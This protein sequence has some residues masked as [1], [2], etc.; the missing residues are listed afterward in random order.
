MQ[1]EGS[2]RLHT[3]F[4]LLDRSCIISAYHPQNSKEG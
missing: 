3:P 4:S 1:K 2:V